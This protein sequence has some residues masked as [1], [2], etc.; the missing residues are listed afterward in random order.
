MAMRSRRLSANRRLRK[1]FLRQKLR[2]LIQ[3]LK[4]YVSLIAIMCTLNT[5]ANS[6]IAACPKQEGGSK[7]SDQK[8]YGCKNK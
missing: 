4:R 5:Y 6:A 1:R 8:V 2:S 7:K 3:G